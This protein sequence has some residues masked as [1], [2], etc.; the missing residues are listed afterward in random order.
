MYKSSSGCLFS[1][2]DDNIQILLIGKTQVG[3]ST[4]GNIILGFPAFDAKLSAASVTEKIECRENERFGKRL[5]VVDTPGV[6]HTKLKEEDIR[7]EYCKWPEH[8]SPGIH[9]IVLVL[10]AER[11]TKEDDKSVEFFKK[12]FGDNLKDYL[13]VVFT[14]KHKLE[15]Q[16]MTID[17][18]VQTMDK[19]SNLQKLIE[20]SH[21]RYIAFGY[22]GDIN[23]SE[24]EVKELLAMIENIKK[25][26][27]GR[28]Y[29]NELFKRVSEGNNNPTRL[30]LPRCIK[31]VFGMD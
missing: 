18:F 29:S 1:E 3:K 31:N 19:S 8:I 25:R 24:A 10:Q 13:I 6:F 30:R 4:T 14:Q 12:L 9:A 26:N 15:S 2:C 20:K 11:F 27:G 28:Y 17:E 5:V 16:N 21:N 22:K 23:D 7:K